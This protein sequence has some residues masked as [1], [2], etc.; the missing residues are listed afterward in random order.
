[1]MCCVIF[2]GLNQ[3]PHVESGADFTKPFIGDAADPRFFEMNFGEGKVFPG[4]P[5]CLFNGKSVPCFVR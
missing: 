4:G 2:S 1:M 3:N 5:T